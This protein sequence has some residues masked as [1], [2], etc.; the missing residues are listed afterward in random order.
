MTNDDRVRDHADDELQSLFGR[1]AAACPE[2]EPGPHFMS[3][4]WEKIESRGSLWFFFGRLGKPIAAAA[5][6][7][8]LLLVLLNLRSSHSYSDVLSYPDALMASHTA[9]NTYF[10]EGVRS[11]PGAQAAQ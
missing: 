11:V 6:A 8:C 9:E 3:G 1:Y 2:I 10:A 5:A 7:V 4:I